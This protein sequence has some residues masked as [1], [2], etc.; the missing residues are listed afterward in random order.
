[1]PGPGGPGPG[2]PGGPFGG[3]GG[4]ARGVP[5]NSSMAT[6]N[7]VYDFVHTAGPRKYVGPNGGYLFENDQSFSF[8]EWYHQ[9]KLAFDVSRVGSTPER[10]ITFAGA[11]QY[12]KKQPAAYARFTKVTSELEKSFGAKQ[13]EP[14]EYG[15]RIMHEAMVYYGFLKSTTMI[16]E[17]DYRYFLMR[18]ADE[19]NIDLSF[20]GP[21]K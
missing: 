10:H 3:F 19:H 2:G 21:S 12:F 18:F 8:I 5:M 15:R 4:F 7:Q 1:M 16:N 6:A 20:G 14:Q 17:E 9:I 11:Y 13:I